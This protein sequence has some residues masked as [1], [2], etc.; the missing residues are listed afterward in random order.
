MGWWNVGP[1]REF[2]RAAMADTMSRA[3][4]FIL[5]EH[6]HKKSAPA[7]FF[8]AAAPERPASGDAP[9]ALNSI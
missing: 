3:H 9:A 8:S 4:G 5:A 1:I 6:P 2:I 7:D